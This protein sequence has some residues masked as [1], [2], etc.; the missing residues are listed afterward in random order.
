[1]VHGIAAR[2]WR[3]VTV[4]V[5]GSLVWLVA[6]TPPA[7]ALPVHAFNSAFGS[8]GSAPGQFSAPAGIAIN[9]VT[10]G[11]TG[12]VYV[13]DEANNRVEIFSAKGEALVGEFDGAA[14]PAASFAAPNAIAI[15]NSTDSLDPSAGDV[16][17]VD[18]GHG[19]VDKFDA[20]GNYI[21]Q[22]TTGAGGEPLGE[23]L[24]VAVDPAGVLW[25]YQASKE[26]DSYSNAASNLFL[27]S[28]ETPFEEAGHGFA[29]DSQDNLYVNKGAA[30]GERFGK[31][32]SAGAR[33][34]RGFGPEPA[35]A[36]ALDLSTDH[37][38]IDSGEGITAFET[39]EPVGCTPGEGSTQC[40]ISLEQFGAGQLAA[41]HG[42]AVD[43]ASGLVYASNRE[44]DTV[45]VFE[46]L[47][48]PTA[49]TGEAS[50]LSESAATLNGSVD[51]EGVEVSSCGFEYGH[52]S[53]YGE[54]VPC[55]QEPGSGSGAVPVSANV[56]GLEVGIYHFRLSASN[57]NGENHGA[58]HTFVISA[59]PTLANE[60]LV[61]TTATSATIEARI[62]PNGLP[63]TYRL[64]YGT[65]ASY[66]SFSP[67]TSLGGG[68]SA[69]GVQVTLANLTP[70]TTY[71]A[72]V[73]ASNE[74]GSAQGVKDIAFTTQ[75]G[76]GSA[77]ASSCPNRTYFGF[78]P[79]LPDCRA[80]EDVSGE[81]SGEIYTPIAP[82]T[83]NL[84]EQDINTELAVRA[85]EA[86][87]GVAYVAEPG[88]A[89]GG[90]GASGI[91]LGNQ[92]VAARGTEGWSAE[93]ITPQ[94]AAEVI[95]N[96]PV[97][98]AFSASLSIGILGA[99]SSSLAVP[100]TPAGP[101]HCKV[102]Y[103]RTADGSFH[104]LFTET[105]T[106]RN[107]GGIASRD[108]ISP[109]N[110]LFAGANAGTATV[111][112]DS[113]MIFQSPAPLT[114]GA[115]ASE[116]GGNGNN[117]YET[118]AKTTEL[119]SVLPGGETDANAV[120]G[121][122]STGR[123]TTQASRPDFEHVISAD[124]SRIFWTDLTSG[125]IYMRLTGTT[126]TAISEGPAAFWGASADGQ[127][128]FYIEGGALLRADTHSGAHTEL[129]PASAHVEGV[130]GLSQDGAYA[131]FVA[132]GALAPGAENRNCQE[133]KIESEEKSEKG[134]L[135]PEE[136]E[137]IGAEESQ[138]RLGRLPAGRGCNLYL[139]HEGSLTLVAALAAQDDRFRR[140]AGGES[141]KLGAWQA[142][143]GARTAQVADGGEE[144]V[145]Q[146]TQQLTGYDNSSLSKARGREFGAEVFVYEAGTH[147]LTCASCDPS[148]APP[149]AEPNA[150]GTYLPISLS[151]T[152]MR[153]WVSEDGS[154]VFFASS[155]PL[156]PQDVNALQD[157]YEWER[158]GTEGCP[159][160][161]AGG[162]ISVLSGGDSND[163]AFF[164][165]A[166]AD[167]G[168]V[169]LTHRGPL[170]G[171]GLPNSRTGLFD[172]RAGGGF[173]QPPT[174]CAGPSCA[175]QGSGAGQTTIPS[176]A[177]ATAVGG[178]NFPPPAKPVVKNVP[179]PPTRA[180]KLAKALK[181]CKKKKVRSKRIACEK[182]ARK[183]YGS[184][185]A[186]AKK[187]HKSARRTSSGR[188]R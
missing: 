166:S 152:Y 122:P 164:I 161:P 91:G 31:L 129:A 68:F 186:K 104:A 89:G 167:G 142:D 163:L 33:L 59:K 93:N 29:V 72:R 182:Q 127:Y 120:F 169:F 113:G 45:A 3:L 57:A 87:L 172:V 85:K 96:S 150:G 51:P 13:A 119:V 160:G 153:R 92:F 48:T 112:A 155:Q 90:S 183:R 149:A 60:A 1:M 88:G 100:T 50:N 52:S 74:R 78:S 135:T 43:S 37:V 168:D 109:Q 165:D 39:K 69:A 131:Y 146:S 61:A 81:A 42:L 115:S 99:N 26:V 16:Y 108:G 114:A 14:T 181:Q 173:P 179:K 76:A 54:S 106:E 103:D 80:Y 70:G 19:V 35:T 154:R 157:I 64:E 144:L 111:P 24:G 147:S 49:L 20:S 134:E 77:S 73:I 4:A 10:L 141:F 177:S 65:S 130:A 58:D 53:E 185:K 136:A 66:G 25:I 121:G 6:M 117:L 67:E 156:A 41:S 34:I 55:E 40:A 21:G 86:G 140:S 75:S 105:G 116:E 22:I 18:S 126:T 158:A 95:P 71:H 110:L 15:D 63:T 12:D 102:L 187:A 79:S 83:V 28:I 174:G 36:A 188:T 8:E 176:P 82:E 47:H 11:S 23:I 132:E 128:V 162:C 139:A 5:L 171:V 175:G 124:G 46:V 98:E 9:E 125:R 178:E 180:Q 101:P 27:S 133:A 56:S 107:C 138:E 44:A 118:S 32:S 7:Q 38:Y 148:G 145:F 17:V 123:N 94:L 97:Y 151:P 30:G 62:D 170:G 84:T 159:A 184:S 143:L 137:R 2:A